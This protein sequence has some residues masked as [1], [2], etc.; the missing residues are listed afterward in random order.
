[1]G[2][3]IDVRER[4]EAKME[5]STYGANGIAKELED[6]LMKFTAKSEDNKVDAHFVEQTRGVQRNADAEVNITECTR[7]LGNDQLVEANCQDATESSSS[8]DDSDCGVENVDSLG[9]SEASSDFRG[10]AASALDFGGFGEKFR[11]RKKKLTTHWRSFIQ[12]L[13]WRCKWAE[14]QI[15]K[16]QSQA[17]QYDR[18]LEAYN[19][20]KQSQLEDPTLLDGVKSLPFPQS[21][22]RSKILRRK[23]RRISDARTDIA[24]YMS[25]HNL[26][27][28][29]ENRKSFTEA[30]FMNNKLK[31]PEKATLKVNI[32]EEFWVNNELLSFKPG[33]GDNSL[34]NVLAKIDSLQSQIGKLKSRVQ[35]VMSE[36]AEKFSW[37]DSLSLPMPSNA[38]SP[39]HGDRT[40]VGISR[41]ISE[42]RMGDVPESAVRSHGDDPDT[43]VQDGV[44]IDNQ[45]VKEE[46][47]NLEEVK[48]HQMQRPLA[49]KEDP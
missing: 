39:N 6:E 14:L 26:F 9:D 33:D 45:R 17:Q 15:K 29:Y 43:N 1:M 23:R 13:M 18:E 48:I 49:L 32:D 42:Y 12:P 35:R 47:N 11:M 20:R 22:P 7:S 28:Y 36:N 30:A 24:A 31:N 37:A 19:M 4:I 44:L 8:F 38:S 34:E 40:A 25:H 16:L 10:D 2:P 27:S 41:L 46:M 3:G 21:N 5:P